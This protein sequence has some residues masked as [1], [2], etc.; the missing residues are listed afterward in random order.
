[1]RRATI[2]ICFV[3]AACAQEKQRE[4][5]WIDATGKLRDPGQDLAQCDYEL[6]QTRALSPWRPVGP[7]SDPVAVTSGIIFSGP[8][9][10]HFQSCMRARGWI[11]T[12]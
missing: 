2:L 8:A 3:L 6:R 9:P 7:S 10:G 1:M 5:S 12:Y 11:A 4:I